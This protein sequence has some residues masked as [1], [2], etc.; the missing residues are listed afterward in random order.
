MH[1]KEIFAKPIDRNIPGVVHADEIE[2]LQLEVEEYVITDEIAKG[3]DQFFDAYSDYQG[4]NG[5]WISGFFGSGKSH[6]LKMLA[7]LVENQT[8][9]GKPTLEYFKPKCEDDALLRAGME[10]AAAVPSKS[11]LFN[12]DQKAD[13]ISKTEFDAVLAVFVK[14]FNEMLGYYGKQGYVAEFEKDLDGRDLNGRNQYQDFKNAYKEISG[15]DWEEG[16]EEVILEK[17]NIS[18]AYSEASGVSESSAQNIIDHYRQDYKLSI[19]DFAKQVKDYIDKQESSFRLNFF[20]DEVGQYVADN[21]KLMTNLQTIAES[22]ATICDGQSWIFVTAQEDM[23]NVIGEM[24]E[25]GNDFSKIQDRFKTRLKLTSANVDEVIQKRLLQKNEEGVQLCRDLYTGEKNNFGTLFDFADGSIIYQNY[26][27][28]DHFIQCYPFIPYQFTLFQS[29]IENL[30]LHNA[31]EGK[32]RSVGERSMLEVFQEVAVNIADKNVGALATFD[33]MFEGIRSILK[34]QTQRSIQTAEKHLDHEFAIRLL[35]ALFLVKYVKEYKAT[36]RNLRVLLQDG[37]ERDLPA[38]RDDIEEALALLE[39]QTYIQRNGEVFEYLTDEEK[40]VETEIKN[41]NVDVSEVG[42]TLEDILFAEILRDRKIRY[43]GTGQD[44]PFA[45]KLDDKLIGRDHELTIHFVTP[46]SENVDNL[47]VLQANS[48]GRAELMIVMPSD[49]RFVRDLLLYKKTEK[50]IRLNHSTTQQ[51]SVRRILSDRG[52]QNKE[53]LREVQSQARELVGRSKIFVS[54]EE[55]EVSGAE[56]QSRIVKGFGELVSRIYPNLR[57]LQGVTY[58]EEEIPRYLKISQESSLL[59]DDPATF[60]EAEQEVL[61][62]VQANNRNGIR[63][64]LKG[65]TDEFGKRPYG[66]YLAAIQCNLAKL[67][68]RGKIE[69]RSDG[70]LLEDVALE[71]AIRNTHGFPNVVLEP[72]E[73]FTAS[74]I[75]NLKDFYKDFFDQPAGATEARALGKETGEAFRDL[76]NELERL[77]VQ[78]DRYPFLKV[79]QGISTEMTEISTKPYD[80]YLKELRTREEE[81]LKTKEEVLDPVRRFMSGPNREVYDDAREFVNA[82]DPNFKSLEGD[83]P[84]Q[85]R[86]MLDGPEFYKGNQMKDAKKLMGLLRAEIEVVL[87]VEKKHGIESLEELQGRLH[88][89]S[90]YLELSRDKR[91]KYD[92]PFEQAKQEIRQQSLVA[93]VREFSRQFE[94][95][96]YTS[97]LNQL[98]I[99]TTDP[100][101]EGNGRVPVY[102]AFDEV[103]VGF[104]RPFLESKNDIEEYLDLLKAAFIKE[105]KKKIRI[106]I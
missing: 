63:T 23:L 36:P 3:L 38:L 17:E 83:S 90:E 100:D 34:S 14:V 5:V 56:P 78:T 98:T 30:S 61:T 28:E 71:R 72:Q 70:N 12:I 101:D 86:A 58:K 74:Q 33:H 39:Q 60:G 57:M 54:G 51:D 52:F 35:K 44:Y 50:Y 79:L 92:Q 97:L 103:R 8:V 46:F 4:A 94:K 22:L 32:H 69:A 2:T 19:E 53:R 104:D 42:K 45:K 37:F 40:D 15:K 47:A 1:L 11:I 49:D 41:T 65:L 77:A 106:L 89:T 24:E 67:C 25:K 80:Y 21:V 76:V 55:I 82:Q 16:R 18:K 96:E 43:E 84:G 75:R 59:G 95:N 10:K 62:F 26:R 91:Q 29:S 9:N 99:P 88:G 66:W 87:K 102:I 27:S 81:L 31:F 85:L 105:I 13:T 48:L 68:G 93:I 73:D 6:L 7:L 20:V 64:T